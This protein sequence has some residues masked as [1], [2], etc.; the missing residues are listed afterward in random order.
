MAEGHPEGQTVCSITNLEEAAAF[1]DAPAR[2]NAHSTNT[3]TH[4]PLSCFCATLGSS[5]LRFRVHVRSLN[6]CASCLREHEA[7]GRT[8]RPLPGALHMRHPLALSP[9]AIVAS[10]IPPTLRGVIAGAKSVAVAIAIA[11]TES[12]HGPHP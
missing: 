8:S 10:V 12:L 4:S 2:V 5:R 3:H 11:F 7:K 9:V 6:D 1:Y